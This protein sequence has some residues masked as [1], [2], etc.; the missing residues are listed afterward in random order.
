MNVIVDTD[1]GGFVENGWIDNRVEI[2][3]SL[4]LMVAMPDPRCVQPT[5]AQ[6][7]LPKDTEVLR[8]LVR[9]NRIDVAGSGRYPRA[10]VYAVVESAG[11]IRA[12]D[13]VSAACAARSVGPAVART[14]GRTG[15]IDEYTR[16]RAP[17]CCGTPSTWSDDTVSFSMFGWKPATTD[18]RRDTVD[19]KRRTSC[20]A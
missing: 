10:G 18:V 6:E 9:H 15:L 16:R 3:A 14:A 7:D 8:K 11:G 20:A 2:G 5:L 17:T 4:R 1:G 13:P 12:G 19:R